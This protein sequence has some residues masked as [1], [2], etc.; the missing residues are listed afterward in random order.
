MHVSDATLRR[1]AWAMPVV[2]A[3]L[4]V[5]ALALAVA[6][7]LLL[8]MDLA[9]VPVFFL[10]TMVGALVAL[11]QPRNPVGWLL[12]LAG[13][14]AT[15]SFLSDQ[16]AVYETV[17]APGTL[18]ASGLAVWLSLWVWMGMLASLL[19]TVVLFP[20]GRLPS[21]RWRPVSWTAAIVLGLVTATFAFGTPASDAAVPI[22][23]P[24]WIPALT[25]LN[26]LAQD[27]FVVFVALFSIAVLA[28]VVRFRGSRGVERQQLKWIVAAGLAMVVTLS[29][30]LIVTDF[31]WAWIIAV[32]AL[33]LSIGIAILRHRLYDI[34]V[35]IN[36][37]LVYGALSAS[38]LATYAGSVLALSTLLRP[39]AGSSDVAVAGST[40]AVVALF[41]PLRARI[42]RFVDRRFFRSRYDAARTIDRFSARLRDQ[43]DLD[44]LS[45]EL[46]GVVHETVHPAH[47]SLWLRGGR[48]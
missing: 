31:D 41:A 17:T 2:Y 43:V 3:C 14:F 36:R 7:G 37:A 29:S 24:L 16:Y 9:L 33:P 12:S 6:N 27:S 48:S 40:L 11:R 1:A 15:I 23:N 25:P 10:Y 34:D 5:A 44:A 22:A 32:L 28:L 8:G 47:A 19:Y 13:L 30:G 21:P 26:D 38:L 4:G 46:V 39:L 35:L 42:Q 18:P 20:S 45:G